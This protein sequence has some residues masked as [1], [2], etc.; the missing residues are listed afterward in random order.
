MTSKRK[1]SKNTKS[2]VK[3]SSVK[4]AYR[5]VASAVSRP[6]PKAQAE[7]I[8]R[9]GRKKGVMTKVVKA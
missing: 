6:M 4:G 2:N 8:A 7:K 3:S 1:R 5:V 9:S